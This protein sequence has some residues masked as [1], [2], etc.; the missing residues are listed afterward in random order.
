MGENQGNDIFCENQGNDI[1]FENQGKDI[2]FEGAKI[3][4][5]GWE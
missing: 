4:E 2:F 3:F 1:F 5:G